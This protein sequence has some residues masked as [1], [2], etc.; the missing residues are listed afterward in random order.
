M[1]M[2]ACPHC[3]NRAQAEFVFERPL[4]SQVAFDA[5]PETAMKTLYTR[6]NPRGVDE[7]IWRHTHGCGAW[8]LIRR[9]RVS[10]AAQWVRALGPE[11]L[12]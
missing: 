7:E 2:I 12:A 5:A 4:E 8:L 1:K 11:V 9:D 3:G 10:H 6:T